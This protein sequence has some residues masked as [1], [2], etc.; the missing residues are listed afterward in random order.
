MYG[1]MR[2]YP[3]MNRTKM[4][5]MPPKPAI[6]A[7]SSAMTLRRLSSQRRSPNSGRSVRPAFQSRLRSSMSSSAR[8]PKMP[9]MPR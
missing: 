7:S 6:V 4:P 8:K 9:T 1:L 2:L 3:R 5:M